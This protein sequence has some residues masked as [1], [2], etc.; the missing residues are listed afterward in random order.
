MLAP[1]SN[2]P[3]Q[4]SPDAA[5]LHVHLQDGFADDRVE[6]HVGGSAVLRSG[7]VT[8]SLLTGLATEVDTLVSPGETVVRV[9]I[10]SRGIDARHAVELAPGAEHWVGVAIEAGEVQF[11]DSDRSFFYG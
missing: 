4:P 9:E 10:P 3:A 2:N 8:T 6:M 1:M 5:T 7:G 11:S